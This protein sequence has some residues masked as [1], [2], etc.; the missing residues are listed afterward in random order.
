MHGVLVQRADALEG[1]I[2]GSEK[3]ASSSPSPT[4]SRPTRRCAGR[5][6]GSREERG[7]E[8]RKGVSRGE[9]PFLTHPNFLE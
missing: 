7:N 5:S 9:T 2:E 4:R 3:S 1:C 6:A 8:N